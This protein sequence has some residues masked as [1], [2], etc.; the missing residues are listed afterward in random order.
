M[1]KQLN[2]G[3]IKRMQKLAGII[4][5]NT[6]NQLELTPIGELILNYLNSDVESDKPENYHLSSRDEQILM[7]M[8]MY[9][10]GLYGDNKFSNLD[11]FAL[12]IA[13]G[14]YQDP[15]FGKNE[16]IKKINRAIQKG[17]VKI[18]PYNGNPFK[19]S[20]YDSDDEY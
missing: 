15:Q 16:I 6:N 8:G 17:W 12:D 2:E 9:I 5:E 3:I 7:D 11:I 18:V 10:D 19:N 14:E 4:K 20:D 13:S 1:K